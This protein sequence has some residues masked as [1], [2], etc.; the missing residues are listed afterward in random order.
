ME[1]ATQALLIAGGILLAILTL[2]MIAFLTGN[3]ATVGQARAEKVELER[4]AKWNAEWEAYNKKLLYGADVLTL[5]NKAKQNNEEYENSTKYEVKID[6]TANSK[7]KDGTQITTGNIEQY[8]TSI[9]KCIDIRYNSDTGRV[10]EM[11][12][13]LLEDI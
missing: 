8:K 5:V 2:T 6:I 11:T 3:L 1:N 10:S 13:E 12:F 4:L 7:D 9:F